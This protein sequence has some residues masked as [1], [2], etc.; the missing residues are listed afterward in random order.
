MRC[1]LLKANL[2]ALLLSLFSLAAN[3][4]TFTDVVH[5]KNGTI[6]RGVI[7]EQ[8]PG[9]T[10]KVQTADALKIEINYSDIE[11]IT[12]ETSITNKETSIHS[13]S[14][15]ATASLSAI[16]QKEPKKYFFTAG[17]GFIT[18]DV[19]GYSGR[20]SVG[21]R[22]G[23][24]FD[25][26]AF[27]QLSESDKG[28]TGDAENERYSR[29]SMQN[30]GVKGS[31][32]ISTKGAIHP[33]FSLGTGY[34]RSPRTY[35]GRALQEDNGGIGGWYGYY[36]SYFINPAFGIAIPVGKNNRFFTELN[37]NHHTWTKTHLALRGIPDYPKPYK[38]V[39]Y[40]SLLIGVKF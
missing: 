2:C 15:N 21:L 13:G 22:L 19:I 40:A 5:L 4:Q 29:F 33:Y 27:Y 17:A 8:V 23:T 36:Q 37:Y 16:G 6:V 26:Q 20:V 32:T 35:S 28:L 34:G 24:H 10:I 7:I 31:F 30:Y 39:Q 3:A 38:T 9:K 14:S 11:K 12:K 18:G 1:T 25:L